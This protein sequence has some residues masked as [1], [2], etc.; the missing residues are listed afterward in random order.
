ML[1]GLVHAQADVARQDYFRKRGPQAGRPPLLAGVLSRIS[2]GPVS[3]R[4]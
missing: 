2:M 3:A 4:V 1:R